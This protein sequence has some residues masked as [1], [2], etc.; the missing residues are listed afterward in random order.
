VRRVLIVLVAALAVGCGD[1]SERLPA[2]CTGGPAPIR[3]ALAS[4]PAAVRVNGTPISR[5]FNRDASADDVQLVGGSLLAVAQEL[6]D[7]AASEPEG[8]P[9]LRLGYLIGAARRGGSRNG[10]AAELLRRL[11]QESGDLPSR[12]AAYRRGLRAGLAKG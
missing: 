6:G 8:E 5:C 10:L 1:R 9:A 2:A 3:R 12:S 7:A 11:D 4:A